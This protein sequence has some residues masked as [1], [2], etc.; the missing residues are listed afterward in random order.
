M[1]Y[2][3]PKF[4]KLSDMASIDVGRLT[5]NEA[6]T[7]W[8]NTLME[9]FQQIRLNH[10]LHCSSVVFMVRSTTFQNNT[11]SDIVTSS[12]LGGIIEKLRMM[13]ELRKPLK[14]LRAKD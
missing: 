5:E 11:F 4:S 2:I 12:A 13:K 9:I 10:I 3:S 1:K 14:V 6:R 8:V 7:V